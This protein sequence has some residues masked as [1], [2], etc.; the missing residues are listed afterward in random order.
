VIGRIFSSR[1]PVVHESTKKSYGKESNP[2]SSNDATRASGEYALP[3]LP[4]F[5]HEF[6]LEGI[7]VDSHSYVV[8][9]GADHPGMNGKNI[10]KSWSFG[11]TPDMKLSLQHP[12]EACLV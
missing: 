3:S 1:S 2:A 9:I 8:T 4:R 10:R 6:D 7:A 5:F 11:E 12:A